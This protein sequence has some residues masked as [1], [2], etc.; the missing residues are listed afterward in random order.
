MKVFIAICQSMMPSESMYD[1]LGVFK[2]KKDA[3]I[4][5]G[6]NER[7][8]GFEWNDV[9]HPMSDAKFY[10]GPDV[11][12]DYNITDEDILYM[13]EHGYF[14]HWWVEEHDLA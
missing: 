2:T 5:I 10:Q 4:A 3:R 11:P 8:F 13:S 12:E 7:D 6:C 1:I 14:F 9:N